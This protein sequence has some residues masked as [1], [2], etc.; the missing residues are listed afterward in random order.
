MKNIV[1]NNLNY[2]TENELNIK[3]SGKRN[4]FFF[5]LLFI[6]QWLQQ[7]HTGPKTDFSSESCICKRINSVLT[8]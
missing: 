8:A 4:A 7:D 5:I 1:L 2:H 6:L 3:A